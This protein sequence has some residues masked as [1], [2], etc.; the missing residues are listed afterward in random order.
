ME[1]VVQHP[2]RQ[3][4]EERQVPNRSKG[5]QRRFVLLDPVLR[6]PLLVGVGSDAHD[7]RSLAG[8]VRLLCRLDSD[9]RVAHFLRSLFVA[10][11]FIPLD[12]NLLF[13]AAMI[14]EI[15]RPVLIGG[16]F[17]DQLRRITG[18]SACAGGGER[19]HGERDD[20]K[21]FLQLLDSPK[22]FRVLTLNVGHKKV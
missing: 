1:A 22:V 15:K 2:F 9:R 17:A 7:Y 3:E 12:V 8:L 14:P 4:R 18:L 20:G 6:V 21:V 10:F 5:K 16:G 11:D 19:D 13:V